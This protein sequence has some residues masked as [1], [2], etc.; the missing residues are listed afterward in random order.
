MHGI[1]KYLSVMKMHESENNYLDKLPC[2]SHVTCVYFVVHS[3]YENCPESFPGHSIRADIICREYKG[4]RKFA[5]AIKEMIVQR[6]VIGSEKRLVCFVLIPGE[7][8]A[9][10]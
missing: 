7:T 9:N 5:P 10:V 4:H 1:K 2:L 3:Q 6:Y 8:Y